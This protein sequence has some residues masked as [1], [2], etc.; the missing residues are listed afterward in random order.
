[1]WAL[2]SLNH[3][4]SM[5]PRGNAQCALLWQE[6]M[7]KDV[8]AI[9]PLYHRLHFIFSHA[10]LLSDAASVHWRHELDEC[11]I[12][13]HAYIHA[14]RGHFCRAMLC[15]ARLLPSPGVCPSV[16]PSRSWVAPKQI[17]YLR[18]FFTI[19]SQA[20]LVFPYQ[21]EWRYSDGNSPN[22]GVECKGGMKKW[23]FSTNISLYLRNGYS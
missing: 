11:R 5:I 9:D 15:I 18:N 16:R 13:F 17:R 3:T 19:G 10:R 7:P 14:K 2:E 21:T 1:M 12:C 4:S 20:I 8:C 23:R 6:Y 22:L